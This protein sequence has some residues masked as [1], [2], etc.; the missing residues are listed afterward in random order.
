MQNSSIL[1]L[2]KDLVI[3]YVKQNYKNYLKEHNLSKID[4]DQIPNV[5]SEIYTERKEHLQHFLLNSLK[6][7]LSDEYPGD[8]VIKNI[9]RDIFNDDKLCINKLI[10][11][12]KKYQS[13]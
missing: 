6:E 2:I 10:K 12:I 8:L 9:T 7:L 11:E 3:F 5:V 13:L 4:E 1:K